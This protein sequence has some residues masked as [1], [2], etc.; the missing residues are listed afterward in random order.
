[1]VIL[2]RLLHYFANL[3]I[4]VPAAFFTS[5][6]KMLRDFLWGAARHRLA[7][8]KLYLPTDQGGL[9]VPCFEHYY[10]AAQLQWIAWWLADRGREDT[11]TLAP[12]LS[13][14]CIIRLFHPAVRTSVPTPLLLV[15]AYRSFSRCLYLTRTHTPYGPPIPLVGSPSGTGVLTSLELA[16]WHATD[17]QTLGDLYHDGTLTPYE[18]L[19]G[20]GGLPQGQFLR[21]RDT[22]L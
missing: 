7:L 17:I 15:V 13:L 11:S 21:H 2:P 1:M 19:T 12:P 20:E 16:D 4:Y 22:H 5:L 9:A 18:S 10:L 6:M 3:P 8:A 14:D